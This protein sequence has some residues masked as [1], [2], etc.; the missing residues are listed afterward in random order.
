MKLM[1]RRTSQRVGKFEGETNR[2]RHDE[3]SGHQNTSNERGSAKREGN[4]VG[5]GAGR[6]TINP[7]TRVSLRTHP[8][9]SLLSS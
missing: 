9:S 3:L 7:L 6:G 5:R 2:Y 8:L 4:K 1:T